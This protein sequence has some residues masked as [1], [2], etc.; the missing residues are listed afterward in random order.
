MRLRSEDKHDLRKSADR[1]VLISQVSGTYAFLNCAF[2]SADFLRWCWS[3]RNRRHKSLLLFPDSFWYQ[4]WFIVLSDEKKNNL[5]RWIRMH[6]SLI[7]LE[8]SMTYVAPFETVKPESAT[9]IR[10]R[11]VWT[12]WKFCVTVVT[13]WKGRQRNFCKGEMKRA[14]LFSAIEGVNSYLRG[15]QLTSLI[16][17]RF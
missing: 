17:N 1:K 7:G 12:H 2:R 13:I 5:G 11:K 16:S 14:Y 4:S 10:Q 8:S 15:S 6:C 3:K 9:Y